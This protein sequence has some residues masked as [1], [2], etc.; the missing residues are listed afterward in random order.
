M[1]GAESAALYD[2]CGQHPQGPIMPLILQIEKQQGS[3]EQS[4]LCGGLVIL[5]AGEN[6][7]VFV[8]LA[9]IEKA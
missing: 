2:F 3:Q 5:E 1:C 4:L 6:E 8:G 9:L 7:R